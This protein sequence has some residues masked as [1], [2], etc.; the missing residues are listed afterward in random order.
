MIC[1]QVVTLLNRGMEKRVKKPKTRIKFQARNM[2]MRWKSRSEAPVEM[3]MEL[4]PWV[5]YALGS[6]SIGF[7][8]IRM[9]MH[10]RG[11]FWFLSISDGLVVLSCNW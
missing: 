3:E 10:Q 7:I 11:G 6:N 5:L 4:F 9:F 8:S 1:F 2:N